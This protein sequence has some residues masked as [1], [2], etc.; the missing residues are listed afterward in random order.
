MTGWLI[1]NKGFQSQNN[2]RQYE[3]Y[4]KACDK[5][6]IELIFKS[7]FEIMIILSDFVEIRIGELEKPDFVIFLDK[8]IM[9]A[10]QLELIG[11]KVYNS[12]RC[13][14]QCDNKNLSQI[15]FSKNGI[16]TPK[17]IVSKLDFNL[18]FEVNLKFNE[19]V[20]NS[21]DFPFVV[22]EAFGSFGQQVYL[23]NNQKELIEIQRKLWKKEHLYQEFIETSAGKDVRVYVVD[24]K[25]VAS[26]LRRNKSD[27]RANITNG[28]SA[29]EFN[30]TKDFERIAIN[31]AK[32]VDAD[33]AGVDIL[34]GE[35]NKPVI[36][37]VNSNAHFLGLFDLTGI[38]VAEYII[39]HI[40]KKHLIN[41]NSKIKLS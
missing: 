35:N 18:D 15:L 16:T 31:A 32:A 39:K 7:N 2:F 5:N 21:L 28:G 11:F 10:K 38:N 37:E 33:F 1:Y 13:I 20:I 4:K 36:C 17:T 19:F 27:F 6:G 9:L 22:K 24:G 26:L 40:G 25:V 30:I 3:L 34:F 14:E 23:I 29:E 41:N 8:D 12:A